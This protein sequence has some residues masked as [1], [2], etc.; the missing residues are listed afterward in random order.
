M[1]HSLGVHGLARRIYQATAGRKAAASNRSLRE[2]YSGLIQPGSLVFDIGANNGVYASICASLGAH[3]LALEPNA[4]CVRHIELSYGNKSIDVI[5]AV[6]GPKDGLAVLNLSD[7]RDDVSSV[8][9][10]WI[11][12]IKAEHVEYKS[13]WNRKIRLPMLRLDTLIEHFG[14]P[15]YIKI[16]VEGFEEKVL[17]G[18]SSCPRLLSFE[19]NLAF[20]DAAFRCLDKDLFSGQVCFNLVI[21][22]SAQFYLGQWIESRDQLKQI[23]AR[24]G[25]GDSYG[26]IFAKSAE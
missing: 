11:N 8:S 19:Y 9:E 6:A 4:D 23:V 1:T 3:V 16:D 18:L 13:L 24:L 25:R 2:F 5:Q 26:D 17:D 15:A 14:L 21:G 20:L 7:T 10:D 12:A 22:N